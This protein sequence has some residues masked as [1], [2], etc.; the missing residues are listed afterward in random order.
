MLGEANP[1]RDLAVALPIRTLLGDPWIIHRRLDVPRG[2]DGAGYDGMLGG[3]RFLPLQRPDLPR[4]LG[5]LTPVDRRR[6]PWA[7]VDLDLHQLNG[8]P[9]RRANDLV[10]TIFAGDLGGHGLEQS[11]TDGGFHPYGFAVARLFANGH[12]VS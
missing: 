11:P 10:L 4:E 5:F 6:Q 3:G 1:P 12:I 2:I 9:P 7:A 8:R